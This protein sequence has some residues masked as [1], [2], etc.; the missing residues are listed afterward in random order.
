MK[1]YYLGHKIEVSEFGLICITNTAKRLIYT[2]RTR[3][4]FRDGIEWAK[5]VVRSMR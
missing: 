3:L 2:F 5:Y 4:N 1:T